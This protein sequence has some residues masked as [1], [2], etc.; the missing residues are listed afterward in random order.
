MEFPEIPRDTYKNNPLNEVI[1]QVR[2]P[3]I[4]RIASQEPTGFQERIRGAYPIYQES[5]HSLPPEIQRLAPQLADMMPATA[6]KNHDFISRNREWTVGLTS[7]FLALTARNYVHWSEFRERF[8]QLF[9]ALIDEYEPNFF[10]R[11][12][13]RYQNVIFRSE[14]G[15]DGDMPWSKLLRTQ[16]VGVLGS[17][18]LKPSEG[19]VLH[20]RHLTTLSLDRKPSQVKMHYGLVRKDGNAEVGYLIDNDFFTEA[21]IEV[22]DGLDWLSYFNEQ[23]GRAFRW[24]ATERLRTAMEPTRS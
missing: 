7:E 5:S 16:L 18:S 6:Q 4:L 9:G 15:L 13:L 23:A 2:F 1:C 24:C 3:R 12:G 20:D 10:S 14:L 17:K 11:I 8:E 22:N 19:T 21:E